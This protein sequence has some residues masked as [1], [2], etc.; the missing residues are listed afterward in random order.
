MKRKVLRVL[1]LKS[2]LLSVLLGF[3]SC[4]TQDSDHPSNS[5]GNPVSIR[6][7]LLGSD[8]DGNSGSQSSRSSVQGSV[9]QK[10]VII[11][12]SEFIRVSNESVSNSG[13]SGSLA[14]SGSTYLA[15]G[16]P[17]ANGVKFRVLVY[18]SNGNYKISQDYTVGQPATP[19]LLDAGVTYTI[20]AYSY[21]SNTLP[22]LSPSEQGT[23]SSSRVLYDDSN[24]DFMYFNTSFTPSGNGDILNITLRHKLSN[25]IISVNDITNTGITSIV[26]SSL[27][28]HYSNGNFSLSNGNV[29]V[30]GIPSVSSLTFESSQFNPSVVSAVS[31][32]MFINTGT[33]SGSTVSSSFTG[34]ITIGGVTKTISLPNGFTIKPGYQQT[35]NVDLT[36]CGAYLGASGTN[37]KNFMCQNLGADTSL[38]PFIPAA[39]I[40]G[41]K[42]QW[43]YKPV[44]ANVSDSRYYTQSD[45]QSNSGTIPGWN[46]SFLPTTNWSDTSKTVNDPC[47]T[48]YRVP[49]LSQWQSVI[50]NNTNVQ[51]I[52]NWFNSPTNYTSGVLI[53]TRLFLPTAGG[54]YAQD[55]GQ[56][57]DNG[58]YGYYWTSSAYSMFAFSNGNINIGS[59]SWNDGFPV[60]CIAQ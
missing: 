46:Q 26:N 9:E 2:I 20:I 8:Y 58:L 54:R 30:S 53:G 11:S 33:S 44:N 6:M 4:R 49:T 3:L 12:P 22:S 14:S 38:D 25:V 60:R 51:Y 37:W 16:D 10:I 32:R 57:L 55:S 15:A 31:D 40:H 19:M 29:S 34:D 13:V 18:D 39:G 45:D 1:C 5:I 23:L 28:S 35:F 41:A 24:R 56:L 52:G 7:H 50:N 59:T 47:P 27:S 21:N 42:Y 17:L 36:R 43:G 48:G